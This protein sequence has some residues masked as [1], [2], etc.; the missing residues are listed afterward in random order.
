MGWNDEVFFVSDSDINFNKNNDK[1][2][3]KG[4]KDDD[5]DSPLFIWYQN[6]NEDKFRVKI[7]GQDS[8]MY[9]CWSKGNDYG[10][11]DFSTPEAQPIM[12]KIGGRKQLAFSHFKFEYKPTVYI[13]DIELKKEMRKFVGASMLLRVTEKKPHERT[14]YFYSDPRICNQEFPDA[15]AV[16]KIWPLY[17]HLEYK[18]QEAEDYDKEHYQ[19]KDKNIMTK[20]IESSFSYYDKNVSS[21]V[22]VIDLH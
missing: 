14:F 13:Y 6:K 12:F 5:S 1:K 8:K 16:K 20:V 7:I 18:K 22:Q 15:P 4:K 11:N 10:R 3:K 21:E 19:D 9:E 2:G 17:D